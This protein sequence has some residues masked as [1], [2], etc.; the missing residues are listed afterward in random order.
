M[1]IAMATGN[2][3]GNGS[4]DGGCDNGG[5]DDALAAVMKRWRQRLQQLKSFWHW[6]W[7]QRCQRR[8]QL[9]WRRRP[10]TRG[11]Q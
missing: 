2:N 10:S 7:R 5:G 8:L 4:G 6:R 11:R 3:G 1:V 9:R